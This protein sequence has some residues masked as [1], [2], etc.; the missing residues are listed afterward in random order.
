MELVS[1]QYINNISIAATPATAITCIG[2]GTPKLI[3]V[4]HSRFIGALMGGQATSSLLRAFETTRN[5][6]SLRGF[7]KLSVDK[8]LL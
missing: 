7:L 1:S 2:A 4:P 8:S 3:V 5:D 6:L